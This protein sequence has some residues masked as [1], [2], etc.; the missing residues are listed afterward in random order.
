MSRA[1]SGRRNPPESDPGAY[2]SFS[3]GRD[4]HP[5]RPGAGREN[6]H[7][8]API[9]DARYINNHN[10]KQKKQRAPPRPAESLRAGRQD[11]RAVP[12]P[13]V[14]AER[15]KA[16]PADGHRSRSGRRTLR[17]LAG[18]VLPGRTWSGRGSRRDDSTPDRGRGI[19]TRVQNRRYSMASEEYIE[20]MQET[21]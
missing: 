20:R 12:H 6:A 2:W 8:T 11:E 17:S 18:T 19:V 21:G 7:E 3:G 9:A 16:P 4:R 14:P 5:G 1:G 10:R 15:V 13:L